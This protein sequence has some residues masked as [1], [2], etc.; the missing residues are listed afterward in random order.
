M[1]TFQSF[2]EQNESFNNTIQTFQ[3]SGKQY[4][5][6]YNILLSCLHGSSRLKMECP[7]AH[8]KIQMQKK[9]TNVFCVYFVFALHNHKIPHFEL[10][11]EIN[12]ITRRRN[13]C[14]VQ[15][16]DV[17]ATVCWVYN[18]CEILKV[19]QNDFRFSSFQ[20]TIL[21]QCN[22]FLYP[23]SENHFN[24]TYFVTIPPQHAHATL[25]QYCF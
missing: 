20:L 8:S 17:A 19:I 2:P 12:Q 24:I 22:I 6:Q 3:L 14:S 11:D 9:M 4:K 5:Q 10:V 7:Y 13:P 25:L 18:G 15:R 1:P 21:S 16:Q 23:Y